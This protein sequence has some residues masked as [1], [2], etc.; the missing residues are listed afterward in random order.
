MMQYLWLVPTLP[1][2]GFLI[3]SLGYEKHNE[4][5]A[6]IV[7]VGSIAGSA[8][9]TLFIGID[10]LQHGSGEAYTQTLWTWMSIGGFK[11]NITLYLDGLSLVMLGVI[12]GVGSFIHLF[13]TGY[14]HGD[15]GYARFFSYMNLFVA[16]MI[17]LVLGD[18]LLVLYLGW[19]GVGLCS[20]LLI[21][22]WY[23]DPLNGR[24]AR[25]A[26]IVTRV[27]DTAMA[28]GL[29]ILFT[30]L[31][32]LQIQELMQSAQTHWQPGSTLAVVTA[33]LILGGA[34]GKSAQLPLQTW[35]PDAMAGP[36]PVSALIHAATMV[37]A[38]VYLIAR[39]HVLFEL[40]PPA[41]EA[42]GI[43]GVATLLI[44][45]FTALVQTDIKRV[46]AYSTMSQIGYMFFALGV[47]AWSAGIFHLMTHA[48]FKALLFLSAG[49]II[50]ALHHEQDIFKMG[51]L[52]KQMRFTSVCILIGSGALAALPLTSGFASKDKILWEA[53]ASGHHVLWAG[54]LLGA[55]LT[56]FYITRMFVIAFLGE[57][58]T[59]AHASYTTNLWLPLA[60]LATLS[61]VGGLIPMPLAK[62]LPV[63][64]YGDEHAEHMLEAISVAVSLGGIV[65]SWLVYTRAPQLPAKLAEGAGKPFFLLWRSAWAFDWLYDLLFV[66]PFYWMAR[67]NRHD[68]IDSF[69]TGVTHGTKGGYTA[70]TFTQNGKLRWYAAGIAG[71]AVAVIA[72]VMLL[73]V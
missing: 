1:L 70:L 51:G 72:I 38:G 69:Y 15:D 35:L 46:L 64:E 68:F 66:R 71:G 25:K 11:P 47:G 54:G 17:M 67:V 41:Q 55:F 5:S 6:G 73:A 2:A 43:V 27:G 49:H 31:G 21:G 42:V 37:T 59:E 20:Y 56:A 61:V 33:F 4:W 24:A 14:M 28:V 39:T 3:L 32:S 26:F 29:F 48:F 52:W 19:E 50:L 60:V 57:A 7:G 30:Q 36:T 45:G 23:R 34:V 10:Y 18:N 16:A 53:W 44:A 65:L 9:L 13:A 62:V 22:F 40:A 63:H 58:K 12:T 8:L